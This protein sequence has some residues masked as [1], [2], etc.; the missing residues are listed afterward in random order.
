MN[1]KPHRRG[2]TPLSEHARAILNERLRGKCLRYVADELHAAEATIEAASSG[3]PLLPSTR[4][5]LEALLT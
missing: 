5:R 1:V 4:E 2:A 3:G